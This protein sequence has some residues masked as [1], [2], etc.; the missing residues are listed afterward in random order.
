MFINTFCARIGSFYIFSKHTI[1]H[2]FYRFVDKQGVED[3]EFVNL[4][5]HKSM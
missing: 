4:L 3:L 1:H 5:D 2:L